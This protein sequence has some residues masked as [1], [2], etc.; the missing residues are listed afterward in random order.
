MKSIHEFKFLIIKL[1]LC[2][3]KWVGRLDV[4]LCM[5]VVVPHTVHEVRWVLVLKNSSE[6]NCS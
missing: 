5:L 1:C 4:L 3:F 6:V 2:C